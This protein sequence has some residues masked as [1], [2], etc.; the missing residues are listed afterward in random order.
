MNDPSSV[1]G[2]VLILIHQWCHGH[3]SQFNLFDHEVGYTA[4]VALL[5]AMCTHPYSLPSLTVWVGHV[6]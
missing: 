6:Q 3:V 2:L 5:S 1:T 4:D